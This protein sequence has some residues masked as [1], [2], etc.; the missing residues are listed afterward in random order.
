MG[1]HLATVTHIYSGFELENYIFRR[2]QNNTLLTSVLSNLPT[3]IGTIQKQGG[4]WRVGMVL[5]APFASALL[6]GADPNSL[7]EEE[8]PA[9][10]VA[11]LNKHTGAISPLVQKGADIDQQSGP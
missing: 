10:T 7:S 11:V 1:F 5:P 4:S 2:K 8:H 6:Q 3:W 9:L